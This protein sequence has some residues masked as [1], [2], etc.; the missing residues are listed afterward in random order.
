MCT[1]LIAVLSKVRPRLKCAK[2]VKVHIE[3]GVYGNVMLL[4]QTDSEI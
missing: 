1:M 4:N 3:V 2:Y